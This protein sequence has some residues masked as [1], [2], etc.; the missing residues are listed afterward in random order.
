MNRDCRALAIGGFG[1]AGAAVLIWLAFQPENLLCPHDRILDACNP[2][3]LYIG[4]GILVL[5]ASGG[6]AGYVYRHSPTGP[7][8]ESEDVS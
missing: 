8:P 3:F 2:N 1:I 4:S 7:S 6:V 5:L